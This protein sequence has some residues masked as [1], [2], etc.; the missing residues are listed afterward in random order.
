MAM[1]QQNFGSGKVNPASQL[2]VEDHLKKCLSKT[3]TQTW[4]PY[5]NPNLPRAQHSAFGDFPNEYMKAKAA[6][7]TAIKPIAN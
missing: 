4:K 3:T 1:M 5:Q 7:V 6:G 2:L